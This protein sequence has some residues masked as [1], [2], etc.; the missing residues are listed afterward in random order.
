MEN[1][2]WNINTN[3]NNTNGVSVQQMESYRDGEFLNE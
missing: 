1:E 2:S 3:V